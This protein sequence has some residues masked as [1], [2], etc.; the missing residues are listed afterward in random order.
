[1]KKLY[2]RASS[3][4]AVFFQLQ[5]QFK[6]QFTKGADEYRLEFQHNGSKGSVMGFQ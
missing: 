5:N 6:G 3:M 4:D 2:L 1:M